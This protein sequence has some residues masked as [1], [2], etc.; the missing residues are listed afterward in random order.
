MI[1]KILI[2]LLLTTLTGISFAETTVSFADK[3]IQTSF[4]ESFGVDVVLSDSPA[5]RG[6]GIIVRFDPT[7][8]NLSDVAVDTSFWSFANKVFGL[9]DAANGRVEI[10]FASWDLVSGA[11]RIATLTFEPVNTG[12][13]QLSM[14]GS[15][16]NPFI[17][18]SNSP[19]QVS[20]RKA[21]VHVR[22]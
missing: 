8:L 17:D 20:Y 18:G 22:P 10:W 9:D 5:T 19:L 1:R 21:I 11:A 16:G 2:G 14:E 15:E 4:G 7:V 13:T 3:N 6:G 12:N